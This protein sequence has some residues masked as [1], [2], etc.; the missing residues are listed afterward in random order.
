MRTSCQ[1]N[2]Y[3]NFVQL[4]G[5]EDEHILL[6]SQPLGKSQF[7]VNE[8]LCLH[9]HVCRETVCRKK[10]PMVAWNA[11]QMDKLFVAC[12]L[13]SMNIDYSLFRVDIILGS[14]RDWV[15]SACPTQLSNRAPSHRMLE[16]VRPSSRQISLLYFIM[17][18]VQIGTI[19]LI[20]DHTNCEQN[21]KIYLFT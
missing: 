3:S 21:V 7:A 6:K 13:H 16:S 11:I 14:I 8:P 5:R 18:P 4:R 15:N 17:N 20:H 12:L 19:E 10:N 2:A 9:V 1:G